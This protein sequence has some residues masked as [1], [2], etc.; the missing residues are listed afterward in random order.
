[1]QLKYDFIKWISLSFLFLSCTNAS[2]KV[3]REVVDIENFP[4]DFKVDQFYS[5]MKS[6]AKDTLYE[7][8]AGN[9]FFGTPAAIHNVMPQY[10]D[11]TLAY[12]GKT[13]F[14]SIEMVESLKGD[15]ISLCAFKQSKG[16]NDFQ[17]LLAYIESKNG[18]P[19][20]TQGYSFTQFFTYSWD[21]KD[22][23][24]I[25]LVKGK[26]KEY[27][28]SLPGI[29]TAGD[30]SHIDTANAPVINTVIFVFNKKYKKEFTI[31]KIK[32]GEFIRLLPDNFSSIYLETEE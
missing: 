16:T 2:V 3:K 5:T 7:N 23:E 1:M 13:I 17:K 20:R 14:E 31:S 19:K 8:A 30:T 6:S 26:D 28:S 21:L 10:T 9:P 22:R 11:D 15:F 27:I 12:F 4:M 29:K 24:L 18:N 25:L 32:S